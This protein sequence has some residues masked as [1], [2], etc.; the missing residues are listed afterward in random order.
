MNQK[1][2]VVGIGE[3]KETLTILPPAPKHLTLEAKK[4]YQW[5]GQMLCN[6]NRLKEYHLPILEG[7]GAY[8]EQW[9][10]AIK[11]INELNRKNPGLGYIQTFPTGA[12]QISPESTT[13]DKAF[14]GML[15]CSKQ[16]GLD[17]RSEKE[18]KA[19]GD[20]AQGDLFQNLME[21]LKRS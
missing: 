18:L 8:Y 12:R 1:M 15:R 4:G 13:R 11:K 17:P 21:N 6:A 2:K 7:F 9:I 14:E 16:F 3:G 20:P 19:T 10:W 5:M